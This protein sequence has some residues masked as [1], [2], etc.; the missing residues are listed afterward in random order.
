LIAGAKCAGF[1]LSMNKCV[2]ASSGASNFIPP[3]GDS[4]TRNSLQFC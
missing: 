4:H 3:V 1:N 2:S